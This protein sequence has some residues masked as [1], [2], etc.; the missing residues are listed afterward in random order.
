MT[1]VLW[2]N[3]EAAAA[4]FISVPAVVFVTTHMNVTRT[5]N[6]QSIE[7]N[8]SFAGD[9][10]E[11]RFMLYPEIGATTEYNRRFFCGDVAIDY[12]QYMT[13]AELDSAHNQAHPSR[14]TFGS[15]ITV[16]YDRGAGTSVTVWS[17]EGT[18]PLIENGNIP[19]TGVTNTPGVVFH[20]VSDDIQSWLDFG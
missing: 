13:T 7:C 20:H 12:Y 11:A 15:T 9:S 1:C 8:D 10:R 4:Q 5:V 18:F 2:T 6:G 16:T 17:S 14:F 19:L 3:P